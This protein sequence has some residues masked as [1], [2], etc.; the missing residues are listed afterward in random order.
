MAKADLSNH[1]STVSSSLS[2]LACCI[3]NFAGKYWYN[4]TFTTHTYPSHCGSQLSVL[5]EIGYRIFSLTQL[6]QLFTFEV[7]WGGFVGILTYHS[8][9][10]LLHSANTLSPGAL[11]L[12]A[13]NHL[14]KFQVNYVFHL[15]A[16]VPLALSMFLAEQLRSQSR[17]LI[18]V[19]LC[20]GG[21]SLAS[22][23]SQ[24]VERCS[25]SVCHCKRSHQ[26]CF[27]M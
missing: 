4:S 9:S 7:N 8:M 19:T 1:N 3:L 21:G 25:L 18:I 26:G 24:H 22:Y 14:C 27:H 2:R 15:L 13:Y 12:N 6:E 5:G 16:Q 23:C 11:E 20:W 10:A 17:L